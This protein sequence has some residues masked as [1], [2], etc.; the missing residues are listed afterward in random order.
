MSRIADYLRLVKFEHSAFALPFVL[1]AAFIHAGGLPTAWQLG[2]MVVAAVSVRTAA[3]AFNRVID[4]EMDALNPRTRERELPT[5]RVRVSKAWA[6][7]VLC[8][9]LF[10]LAAAML[11]RVCLVLAFPALVVLLG[12]SYTKRFT[13]WCHVAL[14]LSLGI[15]P[16]GAWLA[17]RP[18]LDYPPMVLSLAVI[19]W[20]AGFDIIYALLDEDFDRAHGIHSAVV[21]LGRRGALQV[22]AAL[23]AAFVIL[24]VL[25]GSLTGMGALYYAA[26]G[27][28]AVVLIVEHAIVSPDDLSRVNAAFFTANG[29]AS[30]LILVGVSLEVFL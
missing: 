7:T 10:V 16:M 1:S 27:I 6:L 22:S 20:V 28:V 13:A 19:C 30:L 23:H 3:M 11:N 29:V 2:W 14:G 21:A 26:V 15:A 5:G 18:T 24:V 12:Y 17:V 4:R 9:A 8:S 25:F